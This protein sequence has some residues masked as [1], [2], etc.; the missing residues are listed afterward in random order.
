MMGSKSHRCVPFKESASFDASCLFFSRH[1]FRLVTTNFSVSCSS[2]CISRIHLSSC[3]F[4][5]SSSNSPAHSLC[6]LEPCGKLKNLF[7]SPPS[8]KAS[9]FWI[10]FVLEARRFSVLRSANKTLAP[11]HLLV[12]YGIWLFTDEDLNLYIEV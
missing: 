5:A 11:A 9:F 6:L 2:C 12:C 7:F 1:L 8:R 10:L 3:F 4:R